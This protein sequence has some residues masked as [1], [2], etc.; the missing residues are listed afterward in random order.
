MANLTI[1]P[2]ED[3]Y[4]SKLSQPYDGT[5]SI[6]YVDSI[7]TATLPSGFKILVTINP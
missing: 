6:I 4:E 5:A 1:Y 7:P 3:N 2:L